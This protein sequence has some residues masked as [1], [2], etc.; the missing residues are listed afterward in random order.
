VALRAEIERLQAELARADA[1]V[2]EAK[3]AAQAHADREAQLQA[4]IAELQSRVDTAAE[5]AAMAQ[6]DRVSRDEQHQTEE[7]ALQAALHKLTTEHAELAAQHAAVVAAEAQAQIALQ[8]MTS[9][10]T[11]VTKQAASLQAQYDQMAARAAE[12]QSELEASTTAAAAAVVPSSPAAALPLFDL[13]A[14]RAHAAT[15]L[16]AVEAAAAA[17]VAAA[18]GRCA[19]L[20]HEL[21]ELRQLHRTLEDMHAADA[22]R[23]AAVAATTR[24]EVEEQRLAAAAAQARAAEM[25]ARHEQLLSEH[26]ALQRDAEWVQSQLDA[27]RHALDAQAGLTADATRKAGDAATAIAARDRALAEAAELRNTVE[28]MRADTRVAQ[29]E[30]EL[31]ALRQQLGDAEAGQRAAD[32]ERERFSEELSRA[33]GDAAV[34]HI[35]ISALQVRSLVVSFDHNR[36]LTSVRT[37]AGGAG[38]TAATSPFG[39]RSRS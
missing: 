33:V 15:K 27:T 3:S 32:G 36:S 13:S 1:T 9:E 20:E 21:G 6:R 34:A 37:D 2:T 28:L 24:A 8:R 31:A 7:E 14:E 23:L 4:E 22:A 12:L 17:S 5:T 29:L 18:T 30:S 10:H 16:T 39:R 25:T 26:T 35:E 11:Q 19:E 38:T